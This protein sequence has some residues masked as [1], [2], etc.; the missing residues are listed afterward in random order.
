ML[1]CLSTILLA[2]G[3]QVPLPTSVEDFLQPGTQPDDMVQMLDPL[4]SSNTCQACHG[5]Y[6]QDS[7]HEPWDGWVSNL[8]AQSARDP[9]WHAA[10]TIAN[11]DATDSGEYCIR[12]HAPV[13][14][15]RGHSLPSDGSALED[16]FFENDFDGV[17]CQICHRAVSP[18]PVPGDPVVDESVRAALEFPPGD[19]YG[20]GR[21]ILDPV[22]SRRGPYSDIPNTPGMNLHSP[23]PAIHSPFH[24]RS[25]ACSA[26]HEVRNP[27]TMKQADGT[28][29]PVADGEP[30][31]TQDPYDMYPEQTTWSEWL[32]SSFAD[33]ADVVPDDRFAGNLDG[34]VSTCQDC[35]MPD[36]VA[37]GCFAWE[38]PPWFERQDLGDHGFAGANSWVLK[39]VRS[40]YDD[41]VTG[42][43][44]ER[45]EASLE[46]NIQMM[47][48]ASD[49][50]AWTE[51]NELVVR[52]TNWSGHRL[53]TGYSEGRRMWLQL[54]WL[55]ASGGVVSEA[56]VWNPTTGDIVESSTKVWKSVQVA[57]GAMA[58]AAGVPDGT[59]HHLVLLN[60]TEFDNRIPPA[61]FVNAEFEAFGAPPVGVTYA[62]GQHW[63]D[64]RFVIPVGATQVAVTLLHQTTT[65]D[66]IDSLLENNVTDESGIIAWSLWNDP[67][68]GNR[69]VPIDMDALVFDLEPSTPGDVNG[70]GSVDF[71]DLL[72]I[73]SAWGAPCTGCSED[74]DGDGE[75]G[76]NDLLIVLSNFG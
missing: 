11:Q 56:G 2:L 29:A 76:F 27:V 42:L 45:M 33:G 10:L 28:Y 40:L 35:H 34:P 21:L 72:A 37:G 8:M 5:D 75:V 32:H 59:T 19:G 61:G 3:D 31:P 18:V 51:G 69:S 43:S 16:G 54:R 52:V 22:D 17:N 4:S 55:D 14:W 20:N 57:A 44:T 36:R 70:D 30:H 73:L 26:C 25:A 65:P 39:G 15:Y 6:L 47:R 63:D 74:L 66:Y 38:S 53:P 41:S 60:K 23:T 13:G 48:N 7:F 67:E 1:I 68:I 46:R 24:Q 71:N 9:I 62:D 58:Q 64:S 50:D 12:C 49:M